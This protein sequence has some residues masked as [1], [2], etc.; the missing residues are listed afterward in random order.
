MRVMSTSFGHR[1]GIDTSTNVMVGFA[2]QLSN[3]V[4]KPVVPVCGLIS[5]EHCT[6]MDGGAVMKGGAVSL[7]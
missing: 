4:A 1:P 7:T 3:A 5:Q 2:S 6:V